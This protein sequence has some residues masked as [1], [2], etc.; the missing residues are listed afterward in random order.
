LVEAVEE[1][2]A[3]GKGSWRRGGM[4]IQDRRLVASLGTVALAV[5][6]DYLRFTPF[7]KKAEWTAKDLAAKAKIRLNLA[8]KTVFVLCKTGV[9]NQIGKQGRAY[10]Y[11]IS[12][13]NRKK[14]FGV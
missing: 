3:D 9:I 2:V 6:K 4:S 1:R 14:G 5:K 11:A 7:P 8:Q 12:K 13:G 10:L